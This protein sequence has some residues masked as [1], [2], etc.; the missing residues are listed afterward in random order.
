MGWT[1]GALTV[2]I[3]AFGCGS[4]TAPE[5]KVLDSHYSPKIFGPEDISLGEAIGEATVSKSTLVYDPGDGPALA[6]GWKPARLR[7]EVD[8]GPVAIVT[9]RDDHKP[10]WDV[11]Q[12]IRVIVEDSG[13]FE[14]SVECDEEMNYYDPDGVVAQF[15]GGSDEATAII[16]RPGASRQCTVDLKR[17][18]SNTMFRFAAF[19]DGVVLGDKT[20]GESIEITQ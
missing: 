8:H 17:G 18:G 2:V 9:E 3:L 5:T 4:G 16:N 7:I 15:S 10:S 12:D 6:P 20:F 1:R 13:K 14:V 19:G 11:P